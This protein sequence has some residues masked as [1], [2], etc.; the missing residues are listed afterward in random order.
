MSRNIN[1]LLLIGIIGV[2]VFGSHFGAQFGR[3]VWGNQ[4]I[5]WTPKSM[6]LTLDETKDSFQVLIGGEPLARRLEAGALLAVG[7]QGERYKIVPGDIG[8]RLNNWPR[9]KASF[10]NAA[11]CSAF[12]LGVSFACLVLG[13]TQ[14]IQ[15]RRPGKAAAPDR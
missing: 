7:P 14:I 4:D 9:V 6:A 5:W 3:A 1:P 12:M 15:A 10:L 13:L 11:V 2:T 8:V